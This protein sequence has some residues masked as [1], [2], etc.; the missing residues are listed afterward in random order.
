M[1][2]A[3]STRPVVSAVIASTGFGDSRMMA[4]SIGYFR[5]KARGSAP[6]TPLGSEDPRPH[7]IRIM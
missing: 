6:S 4:T 7:H 2:K 1:L 5:R 3:R